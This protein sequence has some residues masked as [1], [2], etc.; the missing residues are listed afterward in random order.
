MNKLRKWIDDQGMTC[1]EFAKRIGVT[2][3]YLSVIIH[4]KKNISLYV[5]SRIVY[6]TGGEIDY[7]DLIE[8]YAKIRCEDSINSLKDK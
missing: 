3:A 8:D 4:K 7:D 6:E 5:A 2:R 1:T